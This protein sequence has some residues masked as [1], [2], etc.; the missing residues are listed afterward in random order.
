MCPVFVHLGPVDVGEA[1]LGVI[2]VFLF[3]LLWRP[4][5]RKLGEEVPPLT[6]LRIFCFLLAAAVT[7]AIAVLLINRFGPVQVKAYGTMLVVGLAVGTIWCMHEGARR[8]HP[9]AIFID[10][11]IYVLIGGIIG[12]RLLFVALD[13]ASYSAHPQ[14]VLA[15]WEGGLSF[16]GGVLG[17]MIAAFLFARRYRI[18]FGELTDIAAPGLALGFVFGRFGCFFNGCCYGIPTKLPWG[19][20]FPHATWQNGAPISGPVHPTQ[21][22]AALASL[23]IFAILYCFRD[24]MARPGHLFLFYVILYSGWRFFVEQLRYGATAAPFGPLPQFTIGQVASVLIMLGAAA[25]MFVT[26][27]R[28][29]ER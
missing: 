20:V 14:S 11:A 6:P 12:A 27:R 26:G 1:L 2:G 22:Y 23:A 16:H 3:M 25:I 10:F 5:A 17:A 15:L 8:G 29:G 13:W 9:S 19:V 4:A 21:I 24:R 28:G 7:V 18:G